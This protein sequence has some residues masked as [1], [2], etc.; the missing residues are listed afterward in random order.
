MI[1]QARAGQVAYGYAI[2][3]LC[4]GSG[5]TTGTTTACGQPLDA[6]RLFAGLAGKGRQVVKIPLA[7]FTAR[8]LSTATLATPFSV[9]SDAPLTASFANIEIVGGAARDKSALDCGEFK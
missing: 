8:G 1:Y 6:T 5:T 2:G 7:C 9:S 4:A 3:M